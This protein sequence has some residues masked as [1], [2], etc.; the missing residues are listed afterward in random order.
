MDR[1]ANA[2]TTFKWSVGSNPTLSAMTGRWSSAGPLRTQ[3]RASCAGVAPMLHLCDARS[4]Q[5]DI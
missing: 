5:N 4:R 3:G 2:G 1:T